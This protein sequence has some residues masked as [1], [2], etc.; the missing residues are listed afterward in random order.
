MRRLRPLK[1]T[2]NI[3][4]HCFLILF[5]GFSA[6]RIG[7]IPLFVVCGFD[8]VDLFQDWSMGKGKVDKYAE[9]LRERGWT[10]GEEGKG[11]IWTYSISM[12]CHS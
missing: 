11:G 1:P 4:W 6:S 12:W 3:F 5:G 9:Q 7:K 2:P 10:G 8:Y